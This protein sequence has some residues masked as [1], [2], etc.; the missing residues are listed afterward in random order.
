MWTPPQE[1]RY[2]LA[3][4]NDPIFRLERANVL[5][6]EQDTVVATCFEPWRQETLSLTFSSTRAATLHVAE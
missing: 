1:S 4:K 6:R 2:E 5:P 3:T